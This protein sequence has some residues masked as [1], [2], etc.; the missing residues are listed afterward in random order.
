MAQEIN[1]LNH[2]ALLRDKDFHRLSSYIIS[3]YGI[4]LP[5]SKRA[6]LECR[7][8]KRLKAN[9]FSSFSDYIDFVFSPD[10]RATEMSKMI[11]AVSTNTTDFFREPVHFEFLSRTGLKEYISKTGKRKISVW[12]AGC[13]SGEE[14]Y[15]IAMVLKEYANIQQRIDFSITATDISTR[16]LSEGENG[17]Y[18]ENKVASI[19]YN[20]KKENFQKGKNNFENQVRIQPGL[21]KTVNFQ[22]F[23]LLSADFTALGMFD[24]IFCRNVLIYFEK[25]IQY[26]IIKNLCQQL[27]QGGYLFLGHS[28]TTIGFTLPLK[29]IRP[30]IFSKT[31]E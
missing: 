23:N 10:G 6:L 22:K 2:L 21:Q 27:N 11:D 17:I 18:S 5:Q 28:E 14:P 8:Q 29:T 16:M 25:D 30:T 15:T 12:S 3:N 24:I 4:K 9:N 19:P 26:R 13:S 20:I 1:N 7:L 31:E